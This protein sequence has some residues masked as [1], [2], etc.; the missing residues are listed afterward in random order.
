MFPTI[1][2]NAEALRLAAERR[3][4]P[5]M[6]TAFTTI[7]NLMPLVLPMIYGTAEGFARS[8]GPVGLVVVSGLTTSTVLTL[9][10]AGLD[11]FNPCAFFVLLF[12]LGTGVAFTL[13]SGFSQFQALSHGAHVLRGRY[14][15]PDGEEAL[16]LKHSDWIV[17]VGV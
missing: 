1:F 15:D 7:L 5:I 9:V 10:L 8:W 3:F 14:D 16:R 11:A 6:M 17:R 12:L 2:R 4:R 13:W